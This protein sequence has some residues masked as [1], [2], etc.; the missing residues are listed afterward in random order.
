MQL[1][2]QILPCLILAIGILFVPESPRYLVARS[3]DEL[4]LKALASLRRP[5]TTQEELKAEFLQISLQ[6]KLEAEAQAVGNVNIEGQIGW[7]GSVAIAW[8]QWAYLFQTAANRKR[9][10]IGGQRFEPSSMKYFILIC[11]WRSDGH[12]LSVR[13]C[14]SLPY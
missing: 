14:A 2:L 9:V 11:M 7:R 5:G 12:V 6:H 4:A 1:S 13:L 3:Q 10:F 8:S